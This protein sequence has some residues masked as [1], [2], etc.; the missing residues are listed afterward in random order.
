MRTVFLPGAGGRRDFWAPVALRLST[1]DDALFLGWPGFGDEPPDETIRS[2]QDLPAFV[3]RQFDGPCDLVAQSMGG[4]V[5]MLIALGAQDRV[6]RLVLCATSGGIDMSGFQSEDW[7]PG[8]RADIS[9]ST[10]P[11]FLDDRSDLTDELAGITAP[12]LLIWGAEDRVAPPATGYALAGLL[13]DARLVVVPG[14]GHDVAQEQ[15][16]EVA[17]HIDAFLSKPESVASPNTSDA[18][19]GAG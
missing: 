12:T 2:L 11:W 14:A 15:A 10:Q 16:E 13:R 9:E 8:Y 1:R 7:R 18:A 19:R 6:H 4:V 5:A 3:L 17:A